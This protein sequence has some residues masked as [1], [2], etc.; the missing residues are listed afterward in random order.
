MTRRLPPGAAPEPELYS[1]FMREIAPRLAALVA[2]FFLSPAPAGA[3]AAP[4]ASPADWRERLKQA[5]EADPAGVQDAV[6]RKLGGV[7]YARMSAADKDEMDA[8]II[9]LRAQSFLDEATA[10]DQ[11]ATGRLEE[12]W[13]TPLLEC[14]PPTMHKQG[15]LQAAASASLAGRIAAALPDMP[16]A[17]SHYGDKLMS[18]GH[19][20]PALAAYEKSLRLDQSFDGA[21]YGAADARC[22]LG[23]YKA[24]IPELRAYVARHPVEQ[25]ARERLKQCEKAF[26]EASKPAL[27]LPPGAKR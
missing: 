16:A 6:W 5:A 12:M 15:D 14:P 10:F 3:A 17:Q 23:R 22:A 9:D 24:A 7:T 20:A 27:D 4:A 21:R 26:S 2:L 11:T 8:A 19:A 18:L 25:R 1:V 13:K